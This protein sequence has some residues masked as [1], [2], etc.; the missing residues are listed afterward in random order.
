MKTCSKCI[1]TK[2]LDLYPKDRRNTDGYSSWCKFCKSEQSSK[3]NTVRYLIDSKF[4]EAENKRNRENCKDMQK[5]WELQR[6]K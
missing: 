1:K 4:R 5:Y 6:R 3:R 2:S